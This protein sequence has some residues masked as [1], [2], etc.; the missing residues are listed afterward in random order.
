MADRIAWNKNWQLLLHCTQGYSQKGRL[1]YAVHFYK[2]L[3]HVWPKSAI[4]A[5]LFMTW[6]KIYEWICPKLKHLQNMAATAKK[7]NSAHILRLGRPWCETNHD[8]PRLAE[9]RFICE[10]IDYNRIPSKCRFW[11]SKFKK[12]LEASRHKMKQPRPIKTIKSW[13]P[14]S[15]LMLTAVWALLVNLFFEI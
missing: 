1:G 6:S 14:T 15:K 3:P 2:L 8:I 5:T 12:N 7:I 11:C 9:Y 4:F 10:K 13:K